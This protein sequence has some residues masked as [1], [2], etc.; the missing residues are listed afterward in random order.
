MTSGPV[1]EASAKETEVLV[2]L[3]AELQGVLSRLLSGLLSHRSRRFRLH[4]F[5]LHEFKVI[6]R[7][8]FTFKLYAQL[9]REQRLM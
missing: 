7:L 2:I 6:L 8:A 4:E 5:K 1:P 3:V 9:L